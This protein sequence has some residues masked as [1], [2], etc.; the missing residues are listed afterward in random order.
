MR[1]IWMGV[2][3]LALQACYYDN[4]EDLY[5]GGGGDCDTTAVSWQAD[6]KPIIDSRCVSCHSGGFPAGGLALTNHAE[7]A[8]S[9]MRTIDRITRQPGDALL[10]PQGAK[11]D[12]CR[13]DLIIAWANQGAPNN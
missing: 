7:V 6:V 4:E 11:M 1:L 13:I 12:D 3:A 10:M 2:M 8:G 9:I 5:P